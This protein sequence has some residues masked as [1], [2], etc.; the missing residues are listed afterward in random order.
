MTKLKALFYLELALFFVLSV[1]SFLHAP[2]A[3][4][5]Q[6]SGYVT[7]IGTIPPYAGGQMT[8]S[9]ANDSTAPQLPLLNG[10]VFATT[11]IG[12]LESTGFFTM[13]IADNTII[14]PN[15]SH[16]HFILCARTGNPAQPCYPV[17]ITI[18]CVNNSACVNNTLDISSYFANAPVPGAPSLFPMWVDPRSYGAKCNGTNDDTVGIQR[19]VSA[20]GGTP[21]PVGFPGSTCVISSQIVLPHGAA[22]ACEWH[23]FGASQG[24]KVQASASFPANTAMFSRPAGTVTCPQAS[25]I[26]NLTIDANQIA[27]QAISVQEQRL[28]NLNNVTVLDATGGSV[29]AEVI[30]GISGGGPRLV[31]LNSSGLFIDNTATISGAGGAAARP[32][33]GMV[34]YQN[35]DDSE[36]YGTTVDHIK[37]AGIQNFGTNNTLTNFHPWGY[38]PGGPVPNTWPQFGLE[39]HSFAADVVAPEFDTVQLAGID[40]IHGFIKVLGGKLVCNDGGDGSSC[41]PFVIQAESGSSNFF[42]Y[43]TIYQAGSL[44]APNSP[45]NWLGTPD[46][47]N[48]TYLTQ[49]G[50]AQLAGRGGLHLGT[51]GNS[52]TLDSSI[53]TG[54]AK[55]LGGI[56]NNP[57]GAASS[58]ANITPTDETNTASVINSS[59]VA[60]GATWH[61]QRFTSPSGVPSFDQ[62]LVT[63][64]CG[65][66]TYPGTGRCQFGVANLTVP[67]SANFVA[68]DVIIQGACQG[69]TNNKSTWFWRQ[70][71][72]TGANPSDELDLFNDNGSTGAKSLGML[73]NMSFNTVKTKGLFQSAS[74]N[75]AGTCTMAA[76]TCPATNFT[77]PFNSVPTCTCSW[78]GSGTLTGIVKCSATTAAVT[79]SSSVNTDTANMNYLC[80][81]NPN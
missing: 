75:F 34:M 6:S 65:N 36:Q 50:V 73:F 76:G 12:N 56:Q 42:L 17:D 51:G 30:L 26:D 68:P 58:G 79:P 23:L 19:A 72:G 3:V 33:Y 40:S 15:P 45:I 35:V 74:G 48:S 66:A 5:A 47:T 80:A 25:S 69:C 78:N 81:G 22:G 37:I 59:N 31:G 61:R 44:S 39:D 49:W 29:G 60:V 77:T 52:A 10:S 24:A 18:T 57:N 54:P 55:F 32:N 9:F 14:Q 1:M 20:A 27:S 67:T 13:Q 4:R 21:L 64:P 70:A 7:V 43:G 41:G 16:W 11:A 62:Y 28:L 63:P 46:T 53:V 38:G 8:G 71:Y 2:P